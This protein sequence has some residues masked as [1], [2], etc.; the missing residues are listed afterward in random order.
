MTMARG[1]RLLARGGAMV[2]GPALGW[3]KRQQRLWP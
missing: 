3:E 1:Y 2:Y